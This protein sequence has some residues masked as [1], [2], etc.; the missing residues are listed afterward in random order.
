MPRL[1]RLVQWVDARISRQG[2]LGS[3]LIKGVLGT[4]GI[5]ISHAGIGLVTTIVLARILEPSGYGIY[6]YVIALVAFLTIPSE[7]GIPGLA[8][9]EVAIANARRDWDR[10]R[11]FIVRAHLTIGVVS[12]VIV[13]AGAGAL[14]L[15]GHELDA[16]KRT[17]LWMGLALIPLIAFGA[18]RGAMLRGLRKVLLGQLPEQIVRPLVLLGLVLL[19]PLLGRGVD[20][21]ISVMGIHIMAVATAF[22]VGLW[23]F[24][25]QRPKELR[26]AQLGRVDPVWKSSIPFGLSA[27]MQLINGRTDI[28]VLGIFWD[29]ANVGI[30]RVAIQMATVVIFGLQAVNA[31]QGPHIAH[32]FATGQMQRLQKMITRSSQAVLAFALIVIIPIL[33][34]GKMIIRAVFG[35]AYEGA[36]VPLA[37]LCVGQVVNASMGSVASLLNMTGHERDTTKIIMS[38]AALNIALNFT[39]APRWGMIGVAI[40]T[41]VTLI[42]WNLVMWRKVHQRTGIETSPFLRRRRDRPQGQP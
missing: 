37:I 16:A 17:C 3:A 11:G 7:L 26:C 28:L 4:T 38:A 13:S 31:I 20:S 32:L 41:S 33:L 29:D 30:Y 19:L 36:Y 6:S 2:K 40:A 1:S 8:V 25:N 18:L 9:R 14:L 24:L 27:T 22:G 12:V 23:L 21:P 39:L 10:M 35:A 42:T 5:R 15:W 34:F